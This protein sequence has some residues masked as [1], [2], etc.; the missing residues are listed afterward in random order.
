MYEIMISSISLNEVKIT[1]AVP[2]YA[3]GK[4]VEDYDVAFKTEIKSAS[5]RS[6]TINLKDIPIFVQ[7]L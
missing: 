6:V 4:E 2:K 5:G 1:E 7:E 3:S